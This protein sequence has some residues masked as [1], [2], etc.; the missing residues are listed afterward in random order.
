MITLFQM[1]FQDGR[2][3]QVVKIILTPFIDIFEWLVENAPK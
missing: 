3:Q 2:L 1:I